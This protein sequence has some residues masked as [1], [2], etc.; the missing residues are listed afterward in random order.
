[1]WG[2]VIEICTATWL[3]MSPFIFR[4]QHD[5]T[6]LWTDLTVA[7]AITVFAGLSYWPPTRHAH[8]VNLAIAV[9]LCCYGRFANTPPTTVDQNHIAVGIF[10]LMIALIPNYATTPPKQWFDEVEAP[11]RQIRSQ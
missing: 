10:L 7:L 2:R 6:L 11:Q 3:A 1:M 5:L 9:G 8:L 4:M